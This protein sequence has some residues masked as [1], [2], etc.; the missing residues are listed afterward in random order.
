MSG[1][2]GCVRRAAV[3]A[4]A[5]GDSRES[6]VPVPAVLS[7]ISLSSTTAAYNWS[8][9]CR[10]R[11]FLANTARE[12]GSKCHACAAAAVYLLQIFHIQ[13]SFKSFHQTVLISQPTRMKA[14]SM[15]ATAVVLLA[16]VMSGTCVSLGVIKPTCPCPWE[17]AVACHACV[18]A[19]AAPPAAAP[20]SPPL[21]LLPVHSQAWLL[22]T[23]CRVSSTRSTSLARP[24]PMYCLPPFRHFLTRCPTSLPHAA[25]TTLLLQRAGRGPA[26]AGAQVNS[27]VQLDPRR[28]WAMHDA[29]GV[30]MALPKMRLSQ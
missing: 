16:L 10:G 25:H 4:T 3:A 18:D 27:V 12:A 26:T 17:C 13:P 9:Q 19:A 28:C 22:E 8:S 23:S 1:G 11:T 30:V 5:A 15:K 7:L 29:S 14:A 6:S 24:S 2:G 20:P 21:P